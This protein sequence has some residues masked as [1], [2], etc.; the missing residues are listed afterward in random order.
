ME[1][2]IAMEKWN[3][4]EIKMEYDRDCLDKDKSVMEEA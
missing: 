2:G 4:I 3:I 1:I